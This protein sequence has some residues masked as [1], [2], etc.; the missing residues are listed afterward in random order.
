VVVFQSDKST[1]RKRKV[2]T[3]SPT[4]AMKWLRGP[5]GSL[6]KNGIG[7]GPLISFFSFDV[8]E[9]DSVFFRELKSPGRNPDFAWRFSILKGRKLRLAGVL[10][11]FKARPRSQLEVEI[12]WKQQV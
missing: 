1:Y 9:P 6:I 8:N 5:L 4:M 12:R 7:F 2:P 11:E 3:N 10:Q